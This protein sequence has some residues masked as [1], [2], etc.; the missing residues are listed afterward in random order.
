[1]VQGTTYHIG[2]QLSTHG[3]AIVR[4]QTNGDHITSATFVEIAASPSPS[5]TSL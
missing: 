1:M 4:Y 3:A 5:Q 2:L